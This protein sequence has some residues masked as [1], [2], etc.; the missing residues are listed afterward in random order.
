MNAPPGKANRAME[1][2]EADITIQ[3]ILMTNPDLVLREEGEDGSILFDP[4][5]GDVRLLNST[6][7]AAWK[8][9]DG[10]R[11]LS[12][13]VEILKKDFQDVAPDAGDQVLELARDLYALGA[14]GIRSGGLA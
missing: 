10:S 2:K 1:T 8:L 4:D 9:M 13:V 6:A 7:T 5:S 12:E 14:V 11:N 3:S